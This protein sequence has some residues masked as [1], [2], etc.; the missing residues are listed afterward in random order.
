MTLVEQTIGGA[1]ANANIRKTASR[2]IGA[3]AAKR[4]VAL[5][6]ASAV[7]QQTEPA[8]KPLGGRR[9][10]QDGHQDGDEGD[11]SD[12]LRA[13]R[14]DAEQQAGERRWNDA[15]LARAAHEHALGNNAACAA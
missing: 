8:A 3:I 13:G 5:P 9:L 4:R 12:H 7:L 11:G 14:L 6:R 1:S 2:A 10:D 15:G